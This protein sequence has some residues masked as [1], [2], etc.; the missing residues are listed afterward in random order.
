MALVIVKESSYDYRRLRG[1]VFE[2]LSL[3]DRGSIREG[4]RVLIKPNFLAPAP[5]EKALTTHPLVIRAAAEYALSRGG[6]ALVADSNA[7]GSFERL[8]SV[9][10][11]REALEGLPVSLDELRGS[12]EVDTG[13][14]FGKIELSADALQADVIINLPKLKTHSQMGLTLAVKNLF[15]CVVGMRKPEWHYRAGEDKGLFAE[16]L[17][18]IYSVL[19]PAINL[20][21]GILCMEGDGPGTG[22][23]PRHIG[24]LMGSR[25]AVS[26]DKAVCMMVGMEP[27]ELLTNR[28]ARDM[29]MDGEPKMS[30][31]MPEV[32]YF[33]VPET[34]DLM[35]GPRFARKFLRRHIA[36]LPVN[37]RDA[38]KYCD[39][40]VDICP[41]GAIN[42]PGSSLS[43][44]YEKCIR[45]YCC[46][47][48]CPHG[49]MRKRD[50]LLKKI[51]GKYYNAK[52]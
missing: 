1:D 14:K 45:C 50:T 9:C 38:C 17:V 3:L 36:S 5:P 6:K 30:G 8:V 32:K 43:F 23:T 11:V 18:T 48:V 37:V 47:E 28:V 27:H 22:G 51:I 40:C 26:M 19:M 2:M 49:A 13:G 52:R 35:F 20:M 39:E 25:D 31:L 46:L 15:G 16:L 29:G 7:A 21:D 12:R 10:G 34:V 41:A 33:K 44:D 42:N 4:A 24:V